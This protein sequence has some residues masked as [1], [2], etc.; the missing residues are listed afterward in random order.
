MVSQLI[1]EIVRSTLK[2]SDKTAL[3]E[4]RLSRSLVFQN[5]LSQTDDVQEALRRVIQDGLTG[6]GKNHP[7]DAEFIRWRFMEGLTIREIGKK[8]ANS[9]ATVYRHQIISLDHLID[10][11]EQQ[12]YLLRKTYLRKIEARINLLPEVSLVGAEPHLTRLL[13][14]VE[15]PDPP[16]IISIE[17]LGGIGK[18]SLANALIREVVLR[19]NCDGVAWVSAKQQDF[20]VGHGIQST[21]VAVIHGALDDD[22][23]VNEILSQLEIPF[24]PDSSTKEKLATLNN[25][26]KQNMYIIFVDNLETVDDYK[27]LLPTLQTL[28][29]PSRFVLTS[30][31]SI[32]AYSGVRSY[33][34][35]PLSWE[36]T[37]QFLVNEA[38]IQKFEALEDDHEA[39]QQIYEVVGGNPLAL[40]LVMGQLH[41]LPLQ[42]VLQNLKEAQGHKTEALYN[43]IYWQVWHALSK[44]GQQTLLAMPLANGG[45]LDQLAAITQLSSPHLMEAIEYLITLSLVDVQGDLISKTY[46]IHRLTETFLLREVAKWGGDEMAR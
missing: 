27:T 21:R 11:I 30:R 16:W 37:Q 31:V 17:G 40:K 42:T 2:T 3:T 14:L 28:V 43:Y 39:Q 33:R 5:A 8:T 9:D 4:D 46:H 25:L 45:D 6:L 22:T 24:S 1:A 36:N 26:F 34:L 35:E 44:V 12:E 41:I 10:I 7:Q 19:N 18:T 29:N 23:L 32:Q 38:Q 20:H 13:S 15:F